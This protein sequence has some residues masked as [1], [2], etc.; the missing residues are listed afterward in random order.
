MNPTTTTTTRRNVMRWSVAAVVAALGRSPLA[1]A[2]DD[3]D[4]DADVIPFLDPQPYDPKRAMLNWDEL[5]ITDWL[6]PTARVYH[7]S[8]YGEAKV[9]A[10]SWRL[11]IGGLVEKPV[12][13]TL[14]QIKARPKVE[15][16]ATLECGG[17]GASPGFRG[18][19]ANVKWAGT[20]LAPI[21]KD[22]GIARE[23]IEVA[24]W[25]ADRKEE[26]IRGGKYP[27]NFARCLSIPMATTRDDVLLGYEMNGQPLTQG[28]GAP[29]RLIVPGWF[30][31]AWV[32][33]L[34]RIEVRDRAL[35]TKFMAKEYVTLRGEEINGK[36]VWTETLVGPIDVKSVVARVVKLK[37]ENGFRVTGA[38]WG[39]VPIKSVEISID[40]GGWMPVKIEERAEPF[41]WRFW[42]FEWKDA[43]A[44]EHTLVSR[45]ID[46]R[47]RVQ[48][49]AD[50]PAIKN[51]KTY[52][53]ANQQWPRRVKV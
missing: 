48:P 28:H 32:K 5:K 19:I 6:T 36:M 23:A 29:L 40:G 30:G 11:D 18:A 25:G 49:T 17:N 41:T 50:D 35:K 10:K 15:V 8:H 21:L 20:P 16:T 4:P 37:G 24:F 33:W 34:E 31:I 42:S 53:E 43:K 46:A 13:M 22:V 39:E 51:K 12:A 14:D 7:V 47:G 45:A 3:A 2:G 44:G 27:Q 1:L 52:W 38:A 9:D 26:E